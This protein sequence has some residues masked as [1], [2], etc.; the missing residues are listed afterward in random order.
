MKSLILGAAVISAALGLEAAQ[1][2]PVANAERAVTGIPG[3]QIEKV[4]VV[5]KTGRRP[6]VRPVRR[7]PAVIIR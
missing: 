1:A 6:M 2:M 4:V 7:R 5:V 3:V